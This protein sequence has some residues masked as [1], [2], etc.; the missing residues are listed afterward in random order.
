M[1]DIQMKE[2]IASILFLKFHLKI[3]RL[4]KQNKKNDPYIH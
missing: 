4:F 2:A 1:E 3:W